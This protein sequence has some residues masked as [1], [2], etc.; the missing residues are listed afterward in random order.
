MTS[1]KCKINVNHKELAVLDLG[2]TLAPWKFCISNYLWG[3][4][5]H[6]PIIFI[7]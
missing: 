1:T 2:F 4:M 5:N 3:N 6:F 7:Y